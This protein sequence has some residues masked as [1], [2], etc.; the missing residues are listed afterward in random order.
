MAAA[1]RTDR[2]GPAGARRDTRDGVALFLAALVAFASY[3]AFAKHMLV[4]TP[5]TMVNL[6]RY[7]AI[8][9]MAAVL[10]YRHRRGQ[11][12][13]GEVPVA[14]W[15]QP[16]QG[17]LV[18]R[19]LMLATVA[20]SFMT[21]LVVMPLAEATAIYFTAPLF[22]VALSPWLLSERVGRVQWIAVGLGFAGM[23]LIVRP[24]GALPLW[25]TL[26]MGLSAVCYAMF[27]ILTRRLSGLVPAPVQ[28]GYMALF[29]LVIT[30][31]PGFFVA[32]P[33]L[34]DLPT[35]LA[36]LAGG[37]VSGLAQL[38][39]L[40]A[41]RRVSAATLAPLNYLQLLMA[42]VI[43]TVWF[44]R[45]PDAWALAGIALILAAGTYLATARRAPRASP[46]EI[47][48]TT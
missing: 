10:L 11:R 8:G 41:F 14:P 7:T 4:T 2:P 15:R 20:T 47:Q 37:G 48:E 44:R 35:A 12:A 19:S 22:M 9:L 30:S 40:A 18:L 33:T 16:H 25:G 36:L 21:A 5:P 42:L 26:A 29:C 32:H 38:L 17:L 39:L 27:Q 28:F 31:V 34:P 46:P 6:G 24:G 3:D 1:A 43:S 13:R 45:P 23:L